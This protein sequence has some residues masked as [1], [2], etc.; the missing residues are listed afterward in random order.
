M[1]FQRQAH[2]HLPSVSAQAAVFTSQHN[3]GEL[4]KLLPRTHYGNMAAIPDLNA[5][6]AARFE[7]NTMLI[8]TCT[9]YANCPVTITTY[10]LLE[11]TE[12]QCKGHTKTHRYGDITVDHELASHPE[13]HPKLSPQQHHTLAAGKKRPTLTALKD[14]IHS[15]IDLNESMEVDEELNVVDNDLPGQYRRNKMAS[16][17]D[18]P[19]S[20]EMSDASI[21]L[22]DAVS[23]LRL[24]GQ[25]RK[26]ERLAKRASAGTKSSR[27]N[28][29]L[30]VE[31][32]LVSTQKAIASSGEST[33]NA[34]SERSLSLSSSN[35]SL[36]LDHPKLEGE[37]E[38]EHGDT[39]FIWVAKSINSRQFVKITAAG[40]KRLGMMAVRY[41]LRYGVN[42][43]VNSERIFTAWRDG[44]AQA[45]VGAL[46]PIVGLC[47]REGW[48]DK[49]LG[50][51]VSDFVGHIL[52]SEV[53]IRQLEIIM[54]TIT[55][56]PARGLGIPGPDPAGAAKQR[57]LDTATRRRKQIEEA[58]ARVRDACD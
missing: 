25:S 19:G 45:F 50:K 52:A 38:G 11:K 34:S 28:S 5:I 35:Q 48:L 44:D 40:L 42:I 46:R 24:E 23:E 31:P 33:P 43:G 27:K 53:S 12:V 21:A 32:S 41:G 15:W 58:E 36:P 39:I 13:L 10:E 1:G 7:G 29:E 6:F 49:V 20:L 17:Q 47:W 57:G 26:S 37:H 18:G 55:G 8:A 2:L 51:D 16:S 14:A 30:D 22:S 56:E 9:C 3:H 4:F 54:D